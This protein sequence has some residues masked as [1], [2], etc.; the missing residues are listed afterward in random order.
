MNNDDSK[1]AQQLESVLRKQTKRLLQNST[2][3]FNRPNG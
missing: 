1:P 2:R 3:F